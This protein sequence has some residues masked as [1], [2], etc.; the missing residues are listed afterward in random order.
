M[1]ETKE[2]RAKIAYVSTSSYNKVGRIH[3]HHFHIN[4]IQIFIWQ[5]MNDDFDGKQAKDCRA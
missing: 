1:N 3:P 2:T 4:I 5:V